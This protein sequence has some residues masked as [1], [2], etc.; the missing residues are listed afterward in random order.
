VV[1]DGV[2]LPTL[3]FCGHRARALRR[4]RP[5]HP[6]AAPPA[7]ERARGGRLLALMVLTDARRPARTTQ[8]GV[9]LVP[10]AE[11]DRSRWDRAKIEEGTA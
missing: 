7:A 10:L 6:L 1:T 11:Q 8:D 5:P 2:E 3:R 4:G 9:S